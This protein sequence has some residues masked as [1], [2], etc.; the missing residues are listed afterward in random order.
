MS[1]FAIFFI[2]LY[3]A[4]L[5]SV[6]A[7]NGAAAFFLYQIVYLFNPEGRWWGSEIPDFRYSF[8]TSIL[9]ILML[10]IRYSELSKAS[11]WRKQPVLAWMLIFLLLYFIAQAYALNPIAHSRFIDYFW[12]LV[13]VM[14]VAYKLLNTEKLVSAAIWVYLL[15]AGYIGYYGTSLGR[16]SS[17]RLSSIGFVDT[18]IDTNGAASVLVPS[19]VLLLYYGWQG[20]WKIRAVVVVCSAFI[21]NALILAN[22]RGAFLGALVGGGLFIGFMLFSRFQKAGQRLTAIAIVICGLAGALSLTDE[23]FWNRMQTLEANEQGQRGGD[24]R[25]RMYFWFGTLK[26]L[27]D[28]P[29]GMGIG[30]F[31][32]LSGVYLDQSKVNDSVQNRAVHSIWFQ[33]LGELGWV[34]FVVF[35]SMLAAIFRIS[36]KAKYYLIMQNRTEIYFKIVALQCALIGFL[37]TASFIDRARAEILYWMILFLASSAN[38][39][40]LQHLAKEKIASERQSLLPG[41]GSNQLNNKQIKAGFQQTLRSNKDL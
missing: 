10:A 22:S 8:L 38:V 40:Y 3:G 32:M 30:G 23:T 39:Y 19:L 27:E 35:L 6:F 36:N 13:V 25:D 24:G 15:G 28:Y 4:G 16:D 33:V 11:P 2:L 17:G 14:L 1:K 37:V 29:Q 5:I 18:S 41:E 34:G 20:N 21:V 31:A 9:M 26:M 7:Y 12:K